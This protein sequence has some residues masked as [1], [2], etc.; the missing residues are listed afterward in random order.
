MQRQNK[1]TQKILQLIDRFQH[2]LIFSSAD[3]HPSNHVSFLPNHIDNTEG[4]SAAEQKYLEGG[5]GGLPG[6]RI[7]WLCYDRNALGQNAERET[8]EKYQI[9]NVIYG[10][11]EK[12][13]KRVGKYKAKFEVVR[14]NLWPVH[15]VGRLDPDTL[16]SSGKG[17]EIE[18]SVKE[19]LLKMKKG[20]NYYHYS[21]GDIPSVESYSILKNN[22]GVYFNDI[23]E[24]L[25]DFSPENIFVCGV[26]TDYCVFS[27]AR[28]LAELNSGWKVYIV[29][30]ASIAIVDGAVEKLI[31][32]T[33]VSLIE[34]SMVGSI[35]FNGNN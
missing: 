32:D 7:A 30:D 3:E 2:D 23:P 34:S 24:M 12:A 16:V 31:E 22:L 6:S 28:D 26:A 19:R 35:V 18:P 33:G 27:T 21:K 11:S 17:A 20:G 13:L 8:V 29:L 15:C 9:C 10:E 4:T 25:D 5:V 1:V 14:Q